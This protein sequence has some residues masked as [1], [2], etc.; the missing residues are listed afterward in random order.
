[1]SE[2]MIPSYYLKKIRADI[3][4]ALIYPSVRSM[5][6]PPIRGRFRR[7]LGVEIETMKY[8]LLGGSRRKRKAGVWGALLPILIVA[9]RES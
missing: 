9:L 4:S 3:R 7:E 6:I 2:T 8:A 5:L 1:M